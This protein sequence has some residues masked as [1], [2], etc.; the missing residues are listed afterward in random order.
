[1]RIWWCLRHLYIKKSGILYKFSRD[2]NVM[3]EKVKEKKSLCLVVFRLLVSGNDR[4]I[5]CVGGG[6]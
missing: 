5:A 1:M 2:G 3:Q 4:L 6:S